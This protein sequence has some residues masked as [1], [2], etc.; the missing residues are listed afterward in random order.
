[1]KALNIYDYAVVAV[2]MVMMVGIGLYFLRYIQG[3]SDYFR[4]ANK[5]N[6]WIAGLSAY[7]SSFSAYMFTG[8]AGVIYQ[9]GLTGTFLLSLT[10]VA[11][12][13]AWLIFAKLWRRSR[14]TTILEFL[15]ERFTR[16]AHQV[17]SWTYIPFNVLYCATALYSL[18][19][20]I[21]SALGINIFSVIWVCGLVIVI[22]TLLGGLWAVCV[23]DVVQFLVL[24]PVCLVLIPLS[25]MQID[26]FEGFAQAMPAGY[27]HV[28]SQQHPWLWLLALF[29]ILVH[30]QNTNPLVQRYFSVRDEKEARRVALMCALLFIASLAIW[31][32][33]PMVVRY[34]YP[35]IGSVINLPN[36]Q[37]GAFVVMA[38]H[39]LPHG[40]IGLMIAAIFAATMSAI[41]SQYN[42]IAGV[43]TKDI[44]QKLYPRE[45]SEKALL[46]VGQLSTLVL[47]MI[48]IWLSL[49]MAKSGAGSFR[50]MM[51]LSSL[52]GT[53]IATPLLL[54]FIYRRAPA[55]SFMFS[56][57]TGGGL[58]LIFF[59]FPPAAQALEGLGPAL[60]FTITTFALFISGAAAFFLAEFFVKPTARQQEKIAA[61]FR[62]L[63]TPVDVAAEISASDIDH[64]PLAR[65]VGW[66]SVILGAVILP[67]ALVPSP[68]LDRMT[69]LA[70]GLS[71]AGF[72]IAMVYFG[73]KRV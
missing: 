64:A 53:P 56:F 41:D 25:I 72:G 34:L 69:N 5:L 21:V 33:P 24:L 20:F 55:Q 60:E 10:G 66:M 15:D 61:F 42:A 51:K 7:M 32:V 36:P 37:E 68:L 16:S 8:G 50:T 70:V 11:I 45:L 2:Y 9:E 44:V 18:A 27:F 48:V 39:V 40:L 30:G 31:T 23:T 57:A 12:L 63:D 38:L 73:K 3:S 52:T 6:W 46:R 58:A 71:L 29:V 62:K 14:V 1:V 13:L 19:I 17:A 22:Y 35:D 43:F 65:F 59:F 54:G 28:P 47:G 4:A 49:T 26:S 67:F